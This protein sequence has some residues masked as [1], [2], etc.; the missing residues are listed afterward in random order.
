MPDPKD[1]DMKV[2]Q[3]KV[4][5]L[6]TAAS[7]LMTLVIFQSVGAL[8]QPRPLAPAAH[9]QATSLDLTTAMERP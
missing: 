9:V 7:T 4:R 2:T 1:R 5:L 6:A 8:A 3:L